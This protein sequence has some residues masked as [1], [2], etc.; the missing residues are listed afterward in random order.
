M[1][2]TVARLSKASRRPLTPKRG[3]KD[4]YKGTRQAFLPGGLRTGAPGKHVIGGKAKY[5]LLD[6]KVRVF[7]APPLDEILNSP[8]KPYVSV[9]VRLSREETQAALGPF[10]DSRGFS[11]EHLLKVAR[12]HAA[13]EEAS[14]PEKRQLLSWPA[15]GTPKPAESEAQPESESLS[16]R[17]ADWETDAKAVQDA[18]A[19][20]DAPSTSTSRPAG[21][22]AS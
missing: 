22:R 12:E 20:E 19:V 16:R 6:D 13:A 15:S 5:R 9:G 18:V 1:F 17:V 7:V 3:N 11:P 14:E 4:Y 2:P 8:L 21:E 10:E